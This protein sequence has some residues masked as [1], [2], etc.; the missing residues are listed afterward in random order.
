MKDIFDLTGKVALVTGGGTGLGRE[1]AVALCNRGARVILAARRKE[2]LQDTVDY[3]TEQGWQATS[4]CMD[5]CDPASV[6]QAFAD[7]AAFGVPDIIVNNAG[8]LAEPNLLDLEADEWD[9]VMATNLKGAWLV[10]KAGVQAMIKADKKGGSIINIASIMSVCAQKGT[11][12]YAASKAGLVQLT[13]TMA[14]EWARFGVR[15]NSIAPGYYSSDMAD[16]YLATELGKAML[17]RIPM[18]RL[19]DGIDLHGPLLL[20]ASDASAYMTGSVITAD[21]G[22]SMPM[23]N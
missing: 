19:G 9:Q 8:I 10:A 16:E 12:P 5:V 2:K 11:G 22:H 18:R 23:T 14:L 15:V 20:L 1:F 3:L 7:T 6:E 21:G 4:V 13:K 17:R